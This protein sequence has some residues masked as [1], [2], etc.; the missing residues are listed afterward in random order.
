MELPA[1][2]HFGRYPLEDVDEPNL[3]REIF[4]YPQPPRIRFGPDIPAPVATSLP[5]SRA[6]ERDEG[7]VALA[8]AIYITDSTFR[9]GR[10]ARPPYTLEWAGRIF[11]LLHAVSAR[12][13]L[14][15]QAEFFL[16]TE[17]D[18]E[19]LDV[20][21]GRGYA[22]PEI[23]GWIRASLADLKLVRD[24]GLRETGILT[25]ASDYHIFLKF[26]STRRKMLSKYL[27]V[28]ST[29]L[30][31][32]IVPRCSFEDVTRADVYGFC[33]PF[34]AQLMR[35]RE[36][37][38]IDV[39]IRLCDTLG[40]GVPY[41][42]AELPRSV[43]GLVRAFIEEAGVPGALLEWHGHNDF[44]KALVNTATAWLCGCAGASGTLLGLGERT[45]NCS[46]ED[47]LDEYGAITGMPDAADRSVV[48][49]IAACYREELGPGFPR[50]KLRWLQ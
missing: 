23:T 41:P 34:A 50:E 13:G 18:R 32:G 46:I 33:I 24:A 16:Y 36:E 25:S 28:V 2:S 22:Y 31:W 19:C 27:D 42:G 17:T 7:G 5:V 6:M 48:K 49:Q 12:E 44:H 20:C 29:A 9:D 21:R 30:E 8:G 10:Q 15:R 4:P 40:L 43:P 3:I 39:K 35:L 47:L 26:G 14:V 37:S 38:G 45:G 1:R 11:D